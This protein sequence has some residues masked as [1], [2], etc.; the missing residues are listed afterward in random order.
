MPYPHKLDQDRILEE[1]VRLVD[2]HGLEG[3][4]TRV[5]AERLGARAPSLYRYFPEKETLVC[6][7]SAR[8]LAELAQELAP[9]QTL[10]ALARAYWAYADRYPHRYDALVR[11]A[12]EGER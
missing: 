11:H 7:V 12:P 5:L 2:E 1:A 8:F 6:A 4:S 10:T 9:H 3:L